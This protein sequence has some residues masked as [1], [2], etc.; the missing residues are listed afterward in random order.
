V[1]ALLRA[2]L[3]KQRSTRSSLSVMGIMLALVLFGVVLHGFAVHA[4]AIASRDGQM[5]VFGW[6]GLGGLFAALAGAISIT[7]EF[8]YGTIRPT[9]LAAPRRG[10]VM[11]AKAC[12]GA[13]L[14]FGLGVVAELLTIGVGAAALDLRGISIQV[15]TADGAQLVVGG[16][17]AAAFW[18]PIGLGLGALVRNQVAAIVALFA[19]LLFAEGLLFGLLPGAGRFLPGIAGGAIAGVTTTGEVQHLVAPGLG[20]LLLA[21]YSAAALGT[22]IIAI[23]RRDIL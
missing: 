13:L 23:D 11:V 8:R 7:S 1:R 17:V 6:G 12:T 5:H 22:G 20:V 19:W 4:D 21:L 9:V 14:G 2:E 3:L 16:A 15:E 10:R 18:A